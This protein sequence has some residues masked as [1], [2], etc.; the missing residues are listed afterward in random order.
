MN[1]RKNWKQNYANQLK[2]LTGQK[3]IWMHCASLGEFEQGRPLIESIKR[4]HPEYRIILTFFSPSG[5]EVCKNYELADSVFYLPYDSKSNA[6]AFLEI[7]SP[8]KIIFIK[9]E[10]WLNY[11]NSI[12]EKK[13]EC[14]LVSAVFKNHHP[15]FK[16]YGKIFIDSLTAFKILFVQDEHSLQLLNSIGIHQVEICGDTRFDRVL[17]IKNKFTPIK[18]IEL[19][20]GASKLI[21]AGSTWPKDE[22]YI[23]DVFKECSFTNTKLIIV[24]HNIEDR[25][26][27]DTVSKIKKRGFN[28]SLYTDGIDPDSEILVIN[29]IGLLSKSYNYAN[30]AYIGG[31]FDNGIHNCLEAAVY[32]VPVT[33]Y[34]EDYKKYNEAIDLLNIK[35]AA[36]AHSVE[37]LKKLWRYY[38]EIQDSNKLAQKLQQYFNSKSKSTDRILSRIRF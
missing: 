3:K 19:F 34:G 10:F 38:F 13:I 5:Y 31:G 26:I 28:F 16:W 25:L 29:T 22:D 23:L 1:G 11:L 4:S 17:E 14:Y 18:E 8:D 20:K 36:N 32:G 27:K 15:F 30:I 9:Y 33:F 7:V 2:K 12:R 21:I 37:E 24:P 35:A 6:N